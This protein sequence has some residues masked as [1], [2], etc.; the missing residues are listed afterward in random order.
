MQPKRHR[1]TGKPSK[2][3]KETKKKVSSKENARN[4]KSGD[5]NHSKQ[6][7]IKQK[8]KKIREIATKKSVQLKKQQNKWNAVFTRVKLEEQ[9]RNTRHNE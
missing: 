4:Y 1:L 6:L 7:I 2:R 9:R 8:N 3:K 5:E